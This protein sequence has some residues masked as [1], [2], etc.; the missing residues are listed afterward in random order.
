[1]LPSFIE[2]GTPPTQ[3]APD[4]P[5]SGEQQGG[6][7]EAVIPDEADGQQD[8]DEASTEDGES[9]TTPPDL[10]ASIDAH[11]GNN[12][13]R[14]DAAPSAVSEPAS[15]PSGKC[16]AGRSVVIKAPGKKP[17][18][19]RIEPEFRVSKNSWRRI[20]A[21][22]SDRAAPPSD[23]TTTPPPNATTPTI[24]IPDPPAAQVSQPQL[25]SDM[26]DDTPA[27]PPPA[28]P[29]K[30]AWEDSDDDADDEGTG[31][32]TY[33]P[34]MH[35]RKRLR[36]EV[37][38]SPPVVE[39][40]SAAAANTIDPS[41]GPT[42]SVD[43][44]GDHLAGIMG[45]MNLGGGADVIIDGEG[46]ASNGSP[47]S[48]QVLGVPG[49]TTPSVALGGPQLALTP[50][51]SNTAAPLEA[52]SPMV[53]VEGD[54]LADALGNLTFDADP[55]VVFDTDG[56]A[57]SGHPSGPSVNG[58]AGNDA[59]QG[60][61]GGGFTFGAPALTQP[62]HMNDEEAPEPGRQLDWLTFWEAFKKVWNKGLNCDTELWQHAHLDESFREQRLLADASEYFQDNWP[63]PDR[64]LS[65]PID[66]AT[67]EQLIIRWAGQPLYE[68]MN[69]HNLGLGQ[70]RSDIPS[71]KKMTK[72]VLDM[73]FRRIRGHWRE[74]WELPKDP[75]ESQ[76]SDEDSSAEDTVTTDD[77]SKPDDE[78]EHQQ[79]QDGDLF[80]VDAPTKPDPRM[81]TDA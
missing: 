60:A 23:V 57:A 43:A 24:P 18:G 76:T 40:Q 73:L 4:A 64:N 56:N 9:H 22:R 36:K 46:R 25:A 42:T 78:G 8:V 53:D 70:A 52:S 39:D 77:P 32:K 58:V 65:V 37:P 7:S 38:V 49:S 55:E 75:E 54:N 34:K 48:P 45:G 72:C 74:H 16:G 11:D 80:F 12:P 35:L 14:A 44:E 1:M 20:K 47:T 21:S 62:F 3:P 31:K 51:T 17:R 13:V 19:A 41:A 79:Q 2:T 71:L 67:L 27:A 6:S 59:T 26:E 29:R 33:R 81:D 63:E 28:P 68:C 15:S 50:S 61:T 10:P 66:I 30:R 69:R 5:A